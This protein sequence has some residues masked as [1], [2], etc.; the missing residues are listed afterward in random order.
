MN[1]NNDWYKTKRIKKEVHPHITLTRHDKIKTQITAYKYF[2]KN[3]VLFQTLQ[4]IM[5]NLFQEIFKV[6]N[7]KRT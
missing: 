6:L 1:I 4:Y 3:D 5:Y 7:Y 2:F